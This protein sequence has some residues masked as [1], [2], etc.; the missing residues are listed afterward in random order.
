MFGDM[1]SDVDI[2]RDDVTMVNVSF[3]EIQRANDII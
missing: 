1:P 2:A 3:R